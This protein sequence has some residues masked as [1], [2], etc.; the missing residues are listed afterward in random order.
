M[1]N[2]LKDVQQVKPDASSAPSR[3]L[4]LYVSPYTVSPRPCILASLAS[5][6]VDIWKDNSSA[7]LER[8]TRILRVRAVVAAL[9]YPPMGSEKV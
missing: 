8:K 1:R 4:G 7:N 9:L 6:K 3:A 5:R 2:D